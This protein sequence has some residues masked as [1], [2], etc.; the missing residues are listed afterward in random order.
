V[1]DDALGGNVSAVAIQSAT[2][3]YCVVSDS[4]YRNSVKAFNPTT[5]EVLGPIFE[6]SDLIADLEIDGDG[7]LL[8]A[9]RAFFDPRLLVFD[10]D[11][12]QP[13]ASIPARLPPLS[14]AIMTRSL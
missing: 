13:V 10:A 6:S 2:R 12:G 11:T 4:S 8:V 9:V 3:G 5:G 7:S 14:I 1:D